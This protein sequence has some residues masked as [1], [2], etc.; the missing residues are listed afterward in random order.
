MITLRM[1][2]DRRQRLDALVSSG[3]FSSR[4]DAIKFAV[5]RLLDEEARRTIDVAI[6]EGYRRIPPTPEE[7]AYAR[8]STI[9]SVSAEPW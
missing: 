3:R 7:D 6:V 9:R 4:A 5:D 2:D 1:A 8:A